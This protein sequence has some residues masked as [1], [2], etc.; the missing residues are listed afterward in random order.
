LTAPDNSR[1]P[2]RRSRILLPST[3]LLLPALLVFALAVR[4]TA[5]FT[6]EISAASDAARVTITKALEEEDAGLL[7]SV[8]T[9]DAV[10]IS[11]SGQSIQGRT[12]IRAAAILAF[13][14]L[15]SGQLEAVRHYISVVDST[16]YETGHYLFQRGEID[17]S[18]PAFSG[19][20]T[21][22]WQQED[23]VWKIARAIG[24]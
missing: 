20:Y 9:D 21:V 15:G 10:V 13:L 12:S 2:D 18:S 17:E 19:H 4:V 5:G 24:L 14:T 7:A 16:G 22:I 23:G 11:S 6:E 1:S 3:W 8:F